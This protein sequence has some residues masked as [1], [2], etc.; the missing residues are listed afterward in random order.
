M[1][2]DVEREIKMD[3]KVHALPSA[4]KGNG[5]AKSSIFGCSLHGNARTKRTCSG[6]TG[7]TIF[8]LLWNE[9]NP[10]LSQK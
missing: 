9:E 2:T 4:D 8:N 7:V 6:L 5:D 3:D 10:K 1:I